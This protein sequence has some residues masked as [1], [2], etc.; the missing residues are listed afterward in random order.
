[1]PQETTIRG[2]LPAGTPEATIAGKGAGQSTEGMPRIDVRTAGEANLADA[3]ERQRIITEISTTAAQMRKAEHKKREEVYKD[4]TKEYALRLIRKEME[5]TTVAEME[6][7]CPNV[8]IVKKI[9]NKKARVYKNPPSR[10]VQV[11]KG[12]SAKK[13]KKPNIMSRLVSKIKN[14]VGAGEPAVPPEQK[15]L[16][17]IADKTGLDAFMKK[18]NRKLE[19]HRNILVMPLP[20]KCNEAG[21]ENLFDIELMVYTPRQ[22]DVVCDAET[23]LRPIALIFSYETQSEADAGSQTYR[24]ATGFNQAIPGPSNDKANTSNKRFVWWSN[25]FHFTT[26]DKGEILPNESP[27]ELIEGTPANPIKTLP[28][29]T[30][31]K[32]QDGNYWAEGGED[33]VDNAILIVLLLADLFYIAKFQGMGILFLTGKD[34]KKNINIGP[35]RVVGMAWD[36]EEGEPEPK[37]S[38]VN[39]NPPIQDH[40]SMIEEL[41]ALTLTTND[42]EPGDV[43]GKLE[44]AK[45]AAS[46]I[47]EIIQRSEISTAIEDEEEIFKNKEPEIIGIILKWMRLY[48]AGNLLSD[49]FAEIK[50]P[51]TDE[52]IDYNL[53][54]DPPSL[55]VNEKEHVDTLGAKQ[56]TALYT[57]RELVA[58]AHP[59]LTEEELTAYIAELDS[60]GQR[61]IAEAQ[62]KFAATGGGEQG[63]FPPKKGEQAAPQPE[64]K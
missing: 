26:N 6:N 31:S 63:G 45:H 17:D 27:E 30:L 1:M 41:I 46:G 59:E 10:I 13:A 4:R 60:D 52:A 8:S 21:A 36:G 33:L 39:A 22:Y 55:V 12:V 14:A 56:K 38:V 7:R 64:K 20:V 23:G 61:A 62:A 5:N 58:D 43:S 47:Q 34:P 37:L 40:L 15:I 35:G 48:G 42:L 28:G 11:E 2:G 24:S 9:I 50:V 25:K 16:D 29:V 18:V 54:F 3:T 44:S 53:K 19:L 32:D 51:Q 57:R 49:K